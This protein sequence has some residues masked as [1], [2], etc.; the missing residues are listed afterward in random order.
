MA[1]NLT[2]GIRGTEHTNFKKRTGSGKN[3]RTHHCAGKFD[4]ANIVSPIAQFPDG[5]VPLGQWSYPFSLQIPDWLPASMGLTVD[6]FE[7]TAMYIS[8]DIEA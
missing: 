3:K 4:F 2:I 7:Q 8:Y 6:N 1:H 5:P